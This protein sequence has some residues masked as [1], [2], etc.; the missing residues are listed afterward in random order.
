MDN[1]NIQSKKLKLCSFLQ[2]PIIFSHKFYKLISTVPKCSL[3][4]FLNIT[5]QVSHP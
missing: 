5:E 4:S 3:Q 2:F 1:F